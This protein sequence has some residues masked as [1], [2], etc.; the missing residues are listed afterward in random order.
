ME[1][2]LSPNTVKLIDELK[3]LVQKKGIVK[4]DVVKKL[5]ELRPHFI[6]QKEPLVTRVIR[7][8]AEYI[9]EYEV[10]D[11]NLLAEEDEEGN[12]EEE[13]DMEGEDSLN[14]VK[15]NFVYLLDLFAHPDNVMNKEELQRVK[16]MYLD[17]DLF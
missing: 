2:T 5:M 8:T 13:I 17:R 12:V 6:E 4:D 10:F 3:A 1:A 14:E 9:E 11:L 16:Q 15:E 7:M